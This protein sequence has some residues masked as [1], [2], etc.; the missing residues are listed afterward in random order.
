MVWLV[1]VALLL[2]LLL[3]PVSL[4]AVYDA[5]GA[6]LWLFLGPVKIKLYPGDKEEQQKKNKVNKTTKARQNDSASGSGGSLLDFFPLV[7]RVFDI[8]G[9]FRRKLRVSVLQLY[10]TVGG[11]DP[12]DQAVNYGKICAWVSGVLPLAEQCLNIKKRDIKINCDFQAEKTTVQA[13]VKL[14]M[15]VGRLLHTVMWHGFGILRE[16]IK[17]MNSRKGGTK[18]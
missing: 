3:L 7:K 11:D 17:I 6:R 1:V 8:F 18:V 15:T 16:Y 5:A 10:L 4:S 2:L 14:M 13:K 12:A 9:H